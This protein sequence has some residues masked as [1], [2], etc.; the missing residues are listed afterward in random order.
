MNY[1]TMLIVSLAVL[2]AS[3]KEKKTETIDN[4]VDKTVEVKVPSPSD[5]LS[6]VLEARVFQSDLASNPNIQLVDVR[7]PEEYSA[8]HLKGAVNYSVT[9]ANFQEQLNK[10]DI[11]LP[12]YVYCKSGGRSA[13]ASEKMKQFGFTEIRDLKGGITAWQE[14]QL[15]TE[16]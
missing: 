9:D 13:R 2:T 16:N 7:T 6:A 5:E 10:L 12:V 8:A 1:P 11:N 3:C 14:L 4:T 15:P